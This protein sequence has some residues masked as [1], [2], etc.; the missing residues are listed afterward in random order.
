LKPSQA[1]ECFLEISDE[2]IMESG[3]HDHVIHV[4]FNVAVQLIREAQLDGPLVGGSCVLQP[5]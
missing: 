2:L 4:S 3:L 1:V 5:E